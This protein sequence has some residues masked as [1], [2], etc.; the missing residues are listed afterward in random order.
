MVGDL[1]HAGHASFCERVRLLGATLGGEV[2]LVVGITNDEEAGPYKRKPILSNDER[3]ASARACKF[4]DEVIPRAPLVTS[5]EFMQ[6]HHIDYVVH[7]DDY[8]VDQV[9]KYYAAAIDTGRY[10]TVPYTPGISTSDLI[11]RCA[12]RA[13]EIGVASDDK[14]QVTAT[15]AFLAGAVLGAAVVLA[16]K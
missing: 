12:K 2:T 1:W 14:D 16:I 6:Q 3:C 8:T 10:K 11:R 7:G 13:K 15:K 4:V 5:A 9:R